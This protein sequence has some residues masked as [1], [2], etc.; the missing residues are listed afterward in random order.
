MA[1][2]G[3]NNRDV[4]R[5]NRIRTIRSIFSCERISQPELAAKVNNSWPTVLQN[6]KELMAM[7]LVQ[8]V[9]TFESTGG[10]RARAFAP[11]RDARLAIGLEITQNHVG[12]ALVNLAG[13]LLSFTREKRPFERSDDYAV[14]LAQLVQGLAEVS[15]CEPEKILGVGVSLPG[16]LDQSGQMLVYSHALGLRNVPTEEFARH[17]PYPCRFINDAN[18]AGLAEVREQES[19]RSLVYLSLSNSVGGAILAGGALYNGDHLRAGEFGHNTLVPNGRL[20]YCGKKGCL[21]A[22]CSAKVL[23]QHTD[24]DL[25]LFFDG[26]RGGDGALRAVWH[27]YLEYLAV[28]VNNLRM[29][30]DC[31]VIVGGYVGGYLA[32]FGEP[33]REML[34]ERNAFESDSSYLKFS[35]YKLEASALGAAL[36][37]VE[38][39]IQAL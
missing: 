15:G 38:D 26:L 3:A 33:L 2:G 32:E 12:V 29:S 22:Y 13:D 5:I 36:L 28:A 34:V 10:R 14:A 9:G 27:E 24:G 37:H 16:I 30:F 4:K 25:A 8:E 6:V 17:I 39:F 11:V 19:S 1:S 7:G 23:S 18:A 31:D 20:C 21:D 35:Q